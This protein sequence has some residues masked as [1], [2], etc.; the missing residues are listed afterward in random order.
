MKLSEFLQD[1][2]LEAVEVLP[3][4]RLINVVCDNGVLYGVQVDN[5]PINVP[6]TRLEPVEYSDNIISVNNLSFNTTE[7]DML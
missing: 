6:V 1:K 2:N 4:N 3:D 5:I 7:Y